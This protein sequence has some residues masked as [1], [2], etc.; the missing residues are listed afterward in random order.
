MKLFRKLILKY[1]W[2]EQSLIFSDFLHS[3]FCEKK[4]LPIKLYLLS[5]TYKNTFFLLFSVLDFV[6]SLLPLDF[7]KSDFSAN[8][9]VVTF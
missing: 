9:F 8:F 7:F 6:V 3:E 2:G 5:I 1:V 4:C